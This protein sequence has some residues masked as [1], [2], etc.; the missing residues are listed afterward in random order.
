MEI[1]YG[2][3]PADYNKKDDI[4][5]IFD[6]IK[7]IDV[8]EFEILIK[9]LLSNPDIKMINFGINTFNSGDW[10]YHFGVQLID[11]YGCRFQKCIDSD[12]ISPYDVAI[13]MKRM[14][15][16]NNLFKQFKDFMIEEIKKANYPGINTLEDYG[17]LIF[18]KISRL[19]CNVLYAYKKIP[20]L[21][22][23]IKDDIDSYPI[24]KKYYIPYD[25]PPNNE[26]CIF[27]REY[28]GY[29]KALQSDAVKNGNHKD[30]YD[31]WRNKWWFS[32]YLISG[33]D[34]ADIAF[35]PIC[36]VWHE[37]KFGQIRKINAK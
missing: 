31:A 11:R 8:K 6:D 19:N 37:D 1:E 36:N 4:P 10:I 17:N 25:M 13:D 32:I 35:C 3:W 20:Y 2:I 5:R 28:P 15:V 18:T 29:I 26:Y 21:P 7:I 9:Y 24:G 34:R 12:N 22:D 33:M 27:E 30:D 16:N 23:E 14:S